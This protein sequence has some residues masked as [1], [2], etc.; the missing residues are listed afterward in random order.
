MSADQFQQLGRPVLCDNL[1][2]GKGRQVRAGESRWKAHV[3]AFVWQRPAQ[4][5]RVG[6]LQL[7]KKKK[8]TKN[9]K[10]K[11]PS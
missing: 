7:K 1:E 2:N 9:L 3:H 6:A 5:C 10:K 8:T 11:K 4:H